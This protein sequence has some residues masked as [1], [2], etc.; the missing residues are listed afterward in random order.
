MALL[1]YVGMFD[2]VSDRSSLVYM[3]VRRISEEA[4]VKDNVQVNK[5]H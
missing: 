3:L 2:V 1:F 4:R 5:L